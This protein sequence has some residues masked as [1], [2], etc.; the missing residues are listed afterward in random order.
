MAIANGNKP[1]QRLI[2]AI[3]SNFSRKSAALEECASCILC[4]SGELRTENKANAHIGDN[5]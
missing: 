5:T 2:W 3:L 1:H 4:A